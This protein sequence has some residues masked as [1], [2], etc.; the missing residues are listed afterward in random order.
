MVFSVEWFELHLK[1]DDPCG[2][3]SVHGVCGI[4]GLLAVGIF[5][6]ERGTVHRPIVGIATLLGFIFPVTSA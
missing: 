4:W 1:V 5:S 3:I 2:S 6:A